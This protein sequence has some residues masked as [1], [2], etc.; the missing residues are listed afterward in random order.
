MRQ[1]WIGSDKLFGILDHFLSKT[2]RIFYDDV[3]TVHTTRPILSTASTIDVRA[4]A[5]GQRL[6]RDD[7]V[8]H[9]DHLDTI[10]TGYIRSVDVSMSLLVPGVQSTEENG[11]TLVIPGSHLWGDER[12]P[13]RT[14]AV[15]ACMVPGEALLFLGSFYHAG[16]ANRTADQNRPV[17]GLFFCGGTHRAEENVYMEFD[18]EQVKTWSEKEQSRM[19]YATSSPNLGFVDFVSPMHIINGTYDP[20]HLV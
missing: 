2:T 16:G 6:H 10:K 3:P 14:E 20:N 1:E 5:A 11:A 18:N 13:K 9:F 19:G 17:H 12:A 4:G 8:H 15:Q 7:K